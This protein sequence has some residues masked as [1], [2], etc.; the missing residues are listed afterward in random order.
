MNFPSRKTFLV[1]LAIAFAAGFVPGFWSTSRAQEADSAKPVGLASGAVAQADA[2]GSEYFTCRAECAKKAHEAYRACVGAGGTREACGEEAKAALE[3]CVSTEC[4]G[5]A[6]PC[7][8][9]CAQAA[10]KKYRECVANGGDRRT[11][12]AE[13]HA[14]LKTC[15][16]ACPKPPWLCRIECL[17]KG[18]EAYRACRDAGG[19]R[20][21]CAE[22]GQAAVKAC[23]EGCGG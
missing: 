9:G 1:S 3:G 18:H 16:S 10:D 5:I 21:A 8:L 4:A 15:L 2:G 14:S 20:P 19:E 7:A 22:Q 17:Q 13:A 12:A 11:C 6:P 23:A